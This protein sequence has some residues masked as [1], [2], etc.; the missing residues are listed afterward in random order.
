MNMSHA[1]MSA[2]QIRAMN[3]AIRRASE[4]GRRAGE[5]VRRAM[6]N[7]D[8]AAIT[9]D[10]MR[11][12]RTELERACRHAAPAPASETDE[13]AIAR[14]SAGCVDMAEIQREVRD[15]LRE[16]EEEIRNNKDMSDADRARALAAI[17]HTRTDM[18]HKIV[19]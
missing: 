16:A 3:E 8:Y 5:A 1:G 17:D 14:L 19:R 12:A 10:A 15:A 11:Q 18:A 2:E 9:R 4:E 13:A 6:A 7:V